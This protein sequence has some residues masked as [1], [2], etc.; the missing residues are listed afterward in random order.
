MDDAKLAKVAYWLDVWA[1]DEHNNK[2]VH[3]DTDRA[4]SIYGSG[5]INCFDDIE[6]K[7]DRMI[8][9]TI[10]VIV[11]EDLSEP[12]KMAILTRYG[13]MANVFDFRRISYADALSQAYD[14]IWILGTKKNLV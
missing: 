3:V 7:I 2:Q 14:R 6:T 13:L 5:G 4:S 10:S 8:A 12:L 9:N 11:Q 1:Q